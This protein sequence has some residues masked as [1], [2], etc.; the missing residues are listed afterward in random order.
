MSDSK[1]LGSNFIFKVL[2]AGDGGVGKTSL[3]HRYVNNKFQED[4][5]LTIGVEFFMKEVDIQDGNNYRLQLW[6]F[7]G[8]AQFKH[9]LPSYVKGATGAIL[10]IDLTRA[11]TLN[12][13]DEWV[14]LLTTENPKLPIIFV[15]TKIDLVD[16]ISVSDEY[17]LEQKVKYDFLDFIKVSSKTGENVNKVFE[18][19]TE[20]IEKTI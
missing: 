5:K 15:G 20:K 10:M 1:P 12:R 17:A 13:L 16:N 19:L 18:N 7:G 11:I 6:D 3:L 4:M 8:E 9:I 2:T 14:N